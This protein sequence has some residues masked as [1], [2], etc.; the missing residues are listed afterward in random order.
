MDDVGWIVN[1]LSEFSALAGTKIPLF[2][3]EEHVIGLV[4]GLIKNHIVFV[5]QG[6]ELMGFIVGSLVP[7]IFNPDIT[8]FTE[9]FWWVAAPFRGTR[10]GLMLINEFVAYGKEH[11]D[12]ITASMT[13]NSPIKDSTFTKRGFVPLEKN[14]LMEVI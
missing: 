1:Q 5:A 9:L 14:F 11:S 10:A 3:S 2:K 4:T 13:A 7:H 8:V 6:K 12:W